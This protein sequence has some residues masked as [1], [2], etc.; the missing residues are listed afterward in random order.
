M[1]EPSPA[2]DPASEIAGADRPD[3]RDCRSFTA[4]ELFAQATHEAAARLRRALGLTGVSKLAQG[5]PGRRVKVAFDGLRRRDRPARRRSR[6]RPTTPR[7]RRRAASARSRPSS[8][9]ARHVDAAPMPQHIP[10]GYG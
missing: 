8:I 7:Q 9:S 6:E 3:A 2:H 1:P 10:W 5:G 4:D